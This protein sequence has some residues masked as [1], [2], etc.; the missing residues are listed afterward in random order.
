MLVLKAA[1]TCYTGALLQKDPETFKRFS[2]EHI[3]SARCVLLKVPKV[4]FGLFHSETKVWWKNRTHAARTLLLPLWIHLFCRGKKTR[5]LYKS[6]WKLRW[7][8]G[9]VHFARKIN[10]DTPQP[11]DII[12]VSILHFFLFFGVLHNA[13]VLSAPLTS[14]ARFYFLNGP[15]QHPNIPL[16]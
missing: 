13:P 9:I 2:G 10:K 3:N 1:F 4:I 8:S 11:D 14:P 15:L 6:D 16:P 5:I 7:I 12:R